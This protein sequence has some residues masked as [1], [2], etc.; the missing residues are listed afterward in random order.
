[1]LQVRWTISF[2]YVSGVVWILWRSK[3]AIIGSYLGLIPIAP[4]CIALFRTCLGLV[5]SLRALSSCI[6]WILWNIRDYEMLIFYIWRTVMFFKL[7]FK[8]LLVLF[9]LLVGEVTS[10]FCSFNPFAV[11]RVYIRK[12]KLCSIYLKWVFSHLV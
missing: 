11:I 2:W 8:W 9:I 10:I 3:L 1:M 5:C 6:S 12:K 7:T 4:C